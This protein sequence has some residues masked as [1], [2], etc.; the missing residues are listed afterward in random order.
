MRAKPE[1][2]GDG[3]GRT[4][5]RFS[6]E[7]ANDLKK[8]YLELKPD[9]DD[10]AEFGFS[11]TA[12]AF[13]VAVL[14]EAEWVIDELDTQAPTKQTLR[15]IREDLFARLS[16]LEEKFRHLPVAFERMLLNI[17][18]GDVADQLKVAMSA[19]DQTAVL[20][21]Q[22]RHLRP[23][24]ENRPLMEE[25]TVRVLHVLEAH[26][27]P[28]DTPRAPDLEAPTHASRILQKIASDLDIELKSSTWRDIIMTVHKAPEESEKAKKVGETEN[29]S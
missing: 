29:R 18:P 4:S 11:S 8:I 28:V 7:L 9:A 6:D 2:Q 3:T 19:V 5:R 14:A 12:D 15:A 1:Y 16:E 22:Y 13:V 24:E 25:M 21:D 20:I 23:A 26:G 10:D 17:L 27:V